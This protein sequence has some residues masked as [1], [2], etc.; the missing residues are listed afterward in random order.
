V[1]E[2]DNWAQDQALDQVF[3][4]LDGSTLADA[5]RLDRFLAWTV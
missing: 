4:G 5:V 1:L 2:G 3:A